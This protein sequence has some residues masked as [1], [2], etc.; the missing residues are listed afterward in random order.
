MGARHDTMQKQEI[1][2]GLCPEEN[3]ITNL[4]KDQQF[5]HALQA[6]SQDLFFR[7][8]LTNDTIEYYGSSCEFLGLDAVVPDYRNYLRQEKIILPDDLEDVCAQVDAMYRGDEEACMYRLYDKHGNINWFKKEYKLIYDNNGNLIAAIGRCYNMQAQKNMENQINFDSLTGCYRKK[9]FE[10]LVINYMNRYPENGHTLLLVDLDNFKAINDNLGHQFGDTVLR[11]VGDKL[12]SIF[13]DSDYIG[14]IG[15]DEFMVFMKSTNNTAIIEFRAHQ[16]LEELDTI[17]RSATHSYRVTASV[18]IACYPQDAN[19]FHE[20]YDCAD[21][22]LYDAKNRGKGDFVFYNPLLSKGTMENTLALDVATRALSQ[23]FDYR[24]VAEIFTTLFDNAE[25]NNAEDTVNSVLSAIGR[26]FAVSRAYIFESSS[27]DNSVYKNTYEWCAEGINPEIDNLQ[28]VALDDFL[29][30][31]NQANEDGIIYCND[32]SMLDKRESQEILESQG[33]QSFLHSYIK[34]DNRFAY[35]VGFDDCECPRVWSPIEITT[36]MHV[37]KIIAQFLHYKQILRDVDSVSN[38]RLSVLNSLNCCAY[39]IDSET[40]Q[41]KYFNS[42][43]K[44]LVPD[45][46][47]GSIC[48]KVMRGHDEECFN[49]PLKTMRKEGCMT[50]RSVIH[51]EPLDIDMLATAS[52]IPSFQGRESLFVCAARVDDMPEFKGDG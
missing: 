29:P 33:I 26:R 25:Q 36:L 7:L 24:L 44:S 16:I 38:E 45:I 27:D 20:L 42:I 10:S 13:R 19:S 3:I 9:V 17:Y 41:I 46:E 35:A 50:T 49:C 48:H 21:L 4:Q 31:F 1:L 34:S 12:K 51:A 18:G 40:H 37:S 30:L 47:I 5:L 15:G 43:T 23:H 32:F 8:D 39:I 22:A 52:L 2:T 14:R 6:L 11:E 28:E